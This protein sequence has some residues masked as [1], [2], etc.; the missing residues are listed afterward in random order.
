[1]SSAEPRAILAR[2]LLDGSGAAP[3]R[4]VL[5]ALE[6]GRIADVTP[7]TGRAAQGAREAEVV[8]PGL[9][10][11][12]INGAGDVQFNDA[13]SVETLARM[14]EAA[15]RGG[16][17]QILPTFL[18]AP[19]QGYARA[20]DV[21]AEAIAAGVPGILGLHLEGPFLSPRRPGIHEAEAIRP[22]T[23]EDLEILTRPFPGPLLLT[24]APEC[25]PPGALAALVRA[26]ITVFAG[27]SEAS[28][29]EIAAAEAEGLR[30]ATHL[31]NAMSQLQGRAPGVVGAVLGSR[32]LY[33]GI[34]ADGHHV[35]WGNVALAARLLP[36]RLCLVSDAMLTLAG[37]RRCFEM[38]GETI[39][40]EEGRLTSAGGTLAGA[41][42]AMDAAAANMVAH[43]GVTAEAAVRMGA[44]NPAAALGLGAARGQVRPGM[45]AD[46]V[47]MDGGLRA[48][49]VLRAGRLSAC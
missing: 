4:D 10:D 34:I 47:L 30:G 26:G 39:T 15:A 5:I 18:T 1:V 3:R 29:A 28:A 6:G 32:R 13:P 14:A 31:F 21:A 22:L 19:G 9:I 44:A 35:D 20:M 8:A 7:A 38:H 41:H 16:T 40:L 25:L 17:A 33:A 2:C 45:P 23:P 36:E 24:L 11:M 48:Q 49:A 27:H 42:L 43:A 12:Q 46:L 37:T